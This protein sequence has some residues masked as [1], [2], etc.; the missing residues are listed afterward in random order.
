MVA[1]LRGRRAGTWKNERL[2]FISKAVTLRRYRNRESVQVINTYTRESNTTIT[3][4]WCS[5]KFFDMVVDEL[6]TRGL[7]H[8]ALVRGSVVGIALA[9]SDALGHN[10]CKRENSLSKTKI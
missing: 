8:P 5:R 9:K 4:L 7:H 3:A 10:D 2:I 6:A 1:Y